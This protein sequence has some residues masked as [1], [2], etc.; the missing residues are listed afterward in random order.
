VDIILVGEAWIDCAP[1]L[2]PAKSDYRHSGVSDSLTAPP[3]L[4]Q[5]LQIFELYFTKQ[6]VRIML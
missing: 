3:C 4:F 6:A 2:Y 5:K 1:G